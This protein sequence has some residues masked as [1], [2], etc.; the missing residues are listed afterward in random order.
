MAKKIKPL[1]DRLV[2]K[3]LEAEEKTKSGIIIP[4]NA[5]E[6]PQQGTVLAV[7]PGKWDEDGE[8]R[9]KMEVAVGDKVLFGKWAATDIKIDGEELLIV[10]EDDV[11]AVMK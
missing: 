7:G 4:D 10:K 3:R 6:K 9:L 1:A 2:V 8:K 5:K 11:I